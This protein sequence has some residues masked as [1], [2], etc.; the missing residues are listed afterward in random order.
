MNLNSLRETIQRVTR[1]IESLKQDLRLVKS[2]SVKAHLKNEIYQKSFRL[3]RLISMN[4]EIIEKKLKG[5]PN[6]AQKKEI[7]QGEDSSK[8]RRRYCKVIKDGSS[9]KPSDPN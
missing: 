1:E 9:P 6:H 2:L 4:S 5:D 7:Q 8:P 3:S